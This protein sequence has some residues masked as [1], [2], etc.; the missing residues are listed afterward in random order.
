L[1]TIDLEIQD[2][3]I[4]Q[5]LPARTCD[6]SQVTIAEGQSKTI[7]DLKSGQLWPCFVDMHTHLDKGH[8]WPRSPNPNGSFDQALE[9]TAQDSDHWTVEDLY[10]RMEFGLKCSY[11][12]GTQ[13]IRTHLDSADRLEEMVWPVFEALRDQWRDRVILQGVSLAPST[14]YLTPAGER[15]AD[16]V[17]ATG[18]ILGAVLFRGLDWQRSLDRLF[19][20]A[21]ERN[22][23]LDF[24]VDESGNPDDRSLHAVALAKLRHGFTQ[25]VICG[26]CCSLAVQPE[27]VAAET[28][29]L[30]KEADLGVVS[31]P[32]CNLY[33][34]DRQD[35][36]TPRWRGVT[37]LRELKAAQVPLALA[38][39]NCRDPFYGFGDHDLLEVFRESVRIAHLDQPYGDWPAAVTQTPATLMGLSN[40]GAIGVGYPAD[41]ILFRGRSFS[42]LLSRPQHDRQVIRQGQ[43]IEA[44]LPDYAELDRL[45]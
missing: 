36:R 23:A 27:A 13:A 44:Q 16:R 1:V 22:L 11:A 25:R 41:L 31:L 2:G 21:Q 33:L 30:V 35:A 4:T 38:S 43:F 9:T 7:V 28:I 5:V 17:A 34:Q 19:E 39:D 29:A 45:H 12:H 18:G 8:I 24:H 40:C 37:A 42:E 3:R 10:A 26:H 15:L 32:L 14:Y 20:L 6:L